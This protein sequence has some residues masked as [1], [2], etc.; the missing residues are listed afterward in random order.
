MT[1][2]KTKN[3]SSNAVRL[4]L[5]AMACLA[6]IA[7]LGGCASITAGMNSVAD[8]LERS[9]AESTAKEMASYQDQKLLSAFVQPGGTPTAGYACSPCGF[10]FKQPEDTLDYLTIDRKGPRVRDQAMLVAENARTPI[11]TTDVGRLFLDNARS[12]NNAV[13]VYGAKV[14]ARIL[15]LSQAK[16][17]TLQGAWYPTDASSCMVEVDPTGAF[18]SIL[19][20]G[21]EL[22]YGVIRTDSAEARDVFTQQ[23]LY[24]LPQSTARFIQERMGSSFSENYRI[25]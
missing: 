13:A 7:T 17:P 3:G 16:Q 4:T 23:R 21:Y 20:V 24:L 18:V 5:R 25:R 11:E 2:E 1:T 15:S 19:A 10:Y 22:S 8:A 12:R 6:L 14:N 9:L